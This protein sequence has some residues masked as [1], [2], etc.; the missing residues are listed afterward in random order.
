ME[1]LEKQD[2]N[3]VKNFIPSWFS[4]TMG[5]G[6][7]SVALF[8]NRN[9][10]PIFDPI[11][12]GIFIF[13]ILLFFIILVPWVIR[14]FKYFENVK[15]DFKDPIL[16]NFFPTVAISIMIMD[17]N[18]ISIGKDLFGIHIYK[19][20]SLALFLI[21]SVGILLF[22]LVIISIMFING[23]VSLEHANC[24][25]LI[26]SVSHLFIPIVGFDL[27]TIFKDNHQFIN[28]IYI[29]S[30]IGIGIGMILFIYVS[31]AIYH[32][33]IF[34]GLTPPKLAP[35]IFI[36][37]VPTT[38]MTTLVTKMS[39]SIP[40]ITYI[41]NAD[42]IKSILNILGLITWGFSLWWFIIS[43]IVICYH[44]IKKELAFSLS[45]WA[46]TFPIGSL[47][48][49]TASINKLYNIIFLNYISIIFTIFLSLIL[50]IISYNTVKGILNK[51]LFLK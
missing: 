50:I 13:S 29:I 46:F 22:G 9:S 6:I 17:V 26:P 8:L 16:S 10:I 23:K 39:F 44:I 21:G 41:E 49:C 4:I 48:V 43:M 14:F 35:T 51:S 34:F 2:I 24:A 28:Y 1:L 3:V 20:V 38:L 5:I 47:A 31:C 37:M 45:W 27:I 11:S 42:S 32:R 33:Y 12:K 18:F 36:G 19:N 7:F 40:F 15:N 30:L 25:W